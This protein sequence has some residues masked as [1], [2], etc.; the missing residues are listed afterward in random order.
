MDKS[1]KISLITLSLLLLLSTLGFSQK[2]IAIGKFID[3]RIIY[4]NNCLHYICYDSI[5]KQ[6]INFEIKLD[7]NNNWGRPIKVTTENS[8]IFYHGIFETYDQKCL[9]YV[10]GNTPCY[11]LG[12]KYSENLE[13]KNEKNLPINNDKVNYNRFPSLT[14]DNKTLY[15]SMLKMDDEYYKS[16]NDNSCDGREMSLTKDN[17]GNWGPPLMLPRPIN[18]FVNT[19]FQILPDNQTAIF[20]SY[21]TSENN[22]QIYTSKKITDEIWTEPKL[23]TIDND[24]FIYFEVYVEK[25]DEIIYSFIKPKETNT[26]YIKSV[27][28]SDFLKLQI[29]APLVVRCIDDATK[30]TISSNIKITNTLNK[31]QIYNLKVAKDS[32]FYSRFNL[33]NK[34]EIKVSSK[35]YLSKIINWQSKTA[36]SSDTI[37]VKLK[38]LNKNDTIEMK[39]ILFEVNSA[40]LKKESLIELDKIIEL[41]K[42]NPE[43]Q[44]EIKAH[45]DNTGNDND[46]FIL[47]GKRA[48]SI[49]QYFTK[50]KIDEKR[51]QTKS[52]GS[53]EPRFP[54]TTAENKRKN[55]RVEFKI[56]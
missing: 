15:Y 10:S 49:K 6:K 5:N 13:F 8:A 44:L 14:T 20:N 3:S 28:L 52:V 56:L 24:G 45:T 31:A 27:K 23:L 55:R 42:E 43:I 16:I 51:L 25:T 17:K 34:Y 32:S 11:H 50:N 26:Y 38:K 18:Y 37:I 2:T 47:S 7:N 9:Y 29:Q 12:L 30:Q 4:Y 35:G 22:P 19:N 53:K 36:N 33:N 39:N 41:L 54:N 48:E 46:N 40:D 1:I 21:R